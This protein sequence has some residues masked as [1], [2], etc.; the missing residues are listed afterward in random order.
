V[1]DGSITTTGPT[2]RFT[3]SSTVGV[4]GGGVTEVA[5]A[6]IAPNPVHG[7]ADLGFALPRAMPVKLTVHD[8]QGR[9]VAVLANGTFGAGR[10]SLSW[11]GLTHGGALPS[12]LYLV[13]LQTAERTEVRKMVWA[14]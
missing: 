2:W 13:R 11:S 6:P 10:H 4:D 9:E 1:S 7:R 14:H 3:T 5:L 12:G 8:V